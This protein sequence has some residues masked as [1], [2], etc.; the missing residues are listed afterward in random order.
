MAIA[1]PPVVIGPRQK[2]RTKATKQLPQSLIESTK[3]V[4]KAQRFDPSTHLNFTDPEKIYS[5]KEIGREGAGISPV[6][7]TT[8]FSLFTQEAIEQIRAE[9]FT[10]E[11]LEN[12]HV[13]SDFASNMLRGYGAK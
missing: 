10:P 2:Q 6:A 8:P 11:I 12:Y 13:K 4:P 5:M 9:L 3:N 1:I 7:L